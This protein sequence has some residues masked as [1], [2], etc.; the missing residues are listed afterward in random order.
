MSSALLFINASRTQWL[1]FGGRD[2][3]LSLLEL[4]LSF[5][6]VAAPVRQV[7]EAYGVWNKQRNTSFG[8]VIVDKSGIVRFH[9][10]GRDEHDRPSLLE[11][12]T[13]LRDSN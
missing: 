10:F 8:T 12:L 1:R 11:I 13:M 3:A 9:R 7:A 5:F 4:E 2:L 6:M